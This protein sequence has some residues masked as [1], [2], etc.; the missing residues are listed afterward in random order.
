MF[1]DQLQPD[2]ILSVSR[3]Y[4]AREP[5]S[6]SRCYGTTAL[7]AADAAATGASRTPATTS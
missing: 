1:L 4:T 6:R 7:A 5:P 2:G 3:W